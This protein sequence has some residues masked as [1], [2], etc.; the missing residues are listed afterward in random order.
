MYNK[1][2]AW[3]WQHSSELLS[4]QL[5]WKPR[6]VR[7]IFCLARVK[8]RLE[9]RWKNDSVA[10]KAL[11]V[12]IT[13]SWRPGDSWIAILQ[14]AISTQ[15]SCKIMVKSIRSRSSRF[16]YMRLLLLQHFISNYWLQCSFYRIPMTF[17]GSVSWAAVLTRVSALPFG[18]RFGVHR[19]RPLLR[20]SQTGIQHWLLPR[21]IDQIFMI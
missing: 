15:K 3:I 1:L 20:N 12:S 6:V 21:C 8:T 4:L 19:V 14:C 5:A 2:G 17:C 9:I 11:S 13:L 7:R 16:L 10:S 18:A